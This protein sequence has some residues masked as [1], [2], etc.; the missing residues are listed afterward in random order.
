MFETYHSTEAHSCVFQVP[1]GKFGLNRN[2]ERMAGNL[3]ISQQPIQI[4][5]KYLARLTT[6]MNAVLEV[7]NSATQLKMI[8][9]TSILTSVIPYLKPEAA[10]SLLSHS[11]MID[12]ENFDVTRIAE[13][14]QPTSKTSHEK[15]SPTDLAASKLLNP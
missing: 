12:E 11:Q 2:T 9:D 6:I 14:T 13:S 7:C 4:Y 10:A 1:P 8:P 3:L 15:K 5:N